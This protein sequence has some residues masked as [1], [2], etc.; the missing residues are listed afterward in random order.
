MTNFDKITLDI[1][2]DGS[3][4]AKDALKES[5]KVLVDHFEAIIADTTFNPELT[6]RVEEVSEE[7]T[8]NPELIGEDA[9][10]ASDNKIKIEDAGFSPRTA[11][12]LLNSGVKTVAGL[13]RLSPLKIEEIKGLGKKGIAEVTEVL[14]KYE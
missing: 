11:N 6:E 14:A 12:A 5:A 10:A 13:K 3:I 4:S 7:S 9:E 8:V 2:T 1:T